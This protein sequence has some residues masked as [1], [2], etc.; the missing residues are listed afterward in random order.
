MTAVWLGKHMMRPGY[1]VCLAD[2]T[3]GHEAIFHL[4]DLY[5]IWSP[6]SQQVSC[7]GNEG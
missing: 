7:Q 1:A 6:E 2:R 5:L 3:N 4:L